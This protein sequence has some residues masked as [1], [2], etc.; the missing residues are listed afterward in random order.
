MSVLR[1][2]VALHRMVGP[3]ALLA[4]HDAG[5][6]VVAYDTFVAPS[7]SLSRSPEDRGQ[8]HATIVDRESCLPR[9]GLPAIPPGGSQD[10]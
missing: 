5:L 7:L 3:F 6:V 10:G 9:R 8:R 2:V 1:R 4:T